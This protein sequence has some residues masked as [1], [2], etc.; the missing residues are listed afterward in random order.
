MALS[1]L[2]RRRIIAL[3]GGQSAILSG[4]IASDSVL[5]GQRQATAPD[6]SN[7]PNPGAPPNTQT[8]AETAARVTPLNPGYPPL[9]VLR[10]GATGN[11]V[12]NDVAAFNSAVAVASVAGG[13]VYVPG[14]HTYVC[15]TNIN[16][17]ASNVRFYGDG[18]S[19]IISFPDATHRYSGIT[20]TGTS[21]SHLSGAQ[22]ENLQLIGGGYPGPSGSGVLTTYCDNVR[23]TSVTSHEW[24]DNAFCC[25]SGKNFQIANCTGYNIGQ[26]ISIFQPSNDVI[27]N[28]NIFYNILLYDG[29]DVEGTGGSNTHA[30][31]SNNL[32]YNLKGKGT[33]GPTQGINVEDTPYA[34]VTGNIV[35]DVS[36][37]S[38]IHLFGAPYSSV[39]GNVAYNAANSTTYSAG[40]GIY[41]G[42]NTGGSTVVG[43]TTHHNA[44]GSMKLTDDATATSHL[45]LV[46]NNNFNEG[47]ITR[48]GNVSLVNTFGNV[49][50]NKG[51]FSG[52]VAVAGTAKTGTANYTTK[53]ARYTVLDD[54]VH[55]Y[56]QVGWSSHTGTGNIQI[57]GL[58][59]TSANAANYPVT[60]RVD[61]MPITGG[62]VP[63]GVVNRSST[64]INLSQW[65]PASG[66]QAAI[67]LPTSCSGL[68]I[69]GFYQTEST[70]S[71]RA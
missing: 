48:S 56:I 51:D 49:A 23:I 3:L 63:M 66:A 33:D 50:A 2:S 17:T 8:P 20:F 54:M 29:I 65:T 61:G 34:T 15:R 47:T 24:S 62:N 6:T 52:A 45:V 13:G 55:F 39:T 14:G 25:R 4:A 7:Q 22:V 21:A 44:L 37:G 57:T 70:D 43:N 28:G 1:S 30:V 19:S 60:I 42:A 18:H 59:F 67:P 9:N 11:G 35:H 40:F 36:N 68:S 71:R 58:P 16:V 12:T 38:C 32:V 46:N 53:V 69:S 5:P 27:I 41:L 10:Y 64:A 26:G 31:V